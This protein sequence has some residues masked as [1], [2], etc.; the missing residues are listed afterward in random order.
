MP[1]QNKTIQDV[2][3]QFEL[4]RL[5]AGKSSGDG[6]SIVGAMQS[7]QRLASMPQGGAMQSLTPI[8]PIDFLAETAMTGASQ[9]E[10][11]NPLAMLLAGALAPG[12]YKKLKTTNT[13]A[14]LKKFDVKVDNPL[15]HNTN[16]H[17][18]RNILKEGKIKAGRFDASSNPK[19]QP[20][21]SLTRNPEYS[22][23]PGQ[24]QD[25]LDIQ[26]VLN[27]KDVMSGRGTKISP[28]VYKGSKKQKDFR[29]KLKLGSP[30]FGKPSPW[31]ESEERVFANWR[32]GIS[33]DNIK[34][35]KVRDADFSKLKNFR[36]KDV[37]T[38]KYKVEYAHNSLSSLLKRAANKKI[39]VIIEPAAEEGVMGLL[40]VMNSK[41]QSKVLKNTKFGG[42]TV[43]LYRGVK[44]WHK[45]KMVKGGKFIG[46]E[47]IFNRRDDMS[48]DPYG[49][50]TTPS[51][52]WASEFA[53]LG[54]L[55]RTKKK[56][57]NIKKEGFVEVDEFGEYFSKQPYMRK[58]NPLQVEANIKKL[59]E[60]MKKQKGIFGDY[61]S[62]VLEFE[63][64]KSYI[65]KFRKETEK[66]GNLFGYSEIFFP[67]GI[68][69][70]F[71][72][73]VHK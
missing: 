38:P 51:S 8:G 32:T 43:T 44:D 46:P 72:K 22:A 55:L 15:Y 31:F 59:N 26:I 40:D 10:G 3:K 7:Q 18:A 35:I 65:N 9:M 68:P 6:E 23:V 63:V 2:Y 33:S 14:L 25:Q 13:P 4:D 52:S 5:Y 21:I 11:M 29:E 70:Q 58:G 69:K 19:N 27:K 71:L 45:G 41:Q 28:Y 30:V 50:F 48:T 61:S 53:G 64:P 60:Y 16:V 66:P 73:K 37:D 56:I 47:K 39:P 20:S 57:K 12:A 17:G 34:A 49:L 67:K 62:K 36:L 54:N 1:P 24:S 42:E